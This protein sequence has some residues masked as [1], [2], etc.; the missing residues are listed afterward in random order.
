MALDIKS[1]CSK[2]CL[3]LELFC[4]YCL[5]IFVITYW[6]CFPFLL[7]SYSCLAAFL[8]L[9]FILIFYFS[10]QMQV[11]EL[12]EIIQFRSPDTTTKLS[13]IVPSLKYDLLVRF[14][15]INY[16]TYRLFF[17]SSFVFWCLVNDYFLVLNTC[18]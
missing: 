7:P 18:S 14:L 11:L 13:N 3:L 10:F 12:L 8:P 4:C 17:S 9:F 6:P 5:Y 16:I 15:S 1:K 2:E